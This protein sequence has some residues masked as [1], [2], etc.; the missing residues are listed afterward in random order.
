MELK[1]RLNRI[2][3]NIRKMYFYHYCTADGVPNTEVIG[4]TLESAG[5]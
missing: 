4:Q 2:H 1:K 3:L 5:K